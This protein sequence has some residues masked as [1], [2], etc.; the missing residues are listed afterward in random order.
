MQNNQVTILIVEDSPTQAEELRYILEKRGFH[1]LVAYNGKEALDILN[2]SI[3]SIV[4][5]DILMPEMDGYEL[6]KK[7]RKDMNLKELPVILVTSLSDPK[8]VIKGLECGANNFV[9]KP[10]DERYLISRINYQLANLELRKDV[11]AEMG[12]NVFFSGENYFITAER[13]QILDLLLSTY[14][15][16]YHQN[17]ELLE[18]QNELKELNEKL[19]AARLQAEQANKAKSDFLANM[20]HELRTPLNSIIGF[21]EMLEDELFGKLNEKQKEYINDIRSSGNHLLR[22]INDILDLSKVEAG[23]MELELS[24]FLLK[25]LLE[26]AMILFKEKAMRHSINLSLEVDPGAALELEADERKLKQIMFNLIGNAM[27]FTG[28]GGS[29]QVT[30]RRGGRDLGLGISEKEPIPSPQPPIPDADFV[31]IS[32]ADTGIGIKPEDMN[33]LFKEFSQVDAGYAKSYEGTGLGLA[34]AKRM[35][36]LHSGNIWVESEYGKGSRFTF[37]IPIRQL[38]E[39]SGK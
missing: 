2:K 20:S 5:S 3:P 10:Y 25:E 9:T 12:I 14:E 1:V 21:S 23:K 33:K 22:L 38:Q 24:G 13:L 34:L 31:E 18:S 19:E 15:T 28:D 26:A 27:K 39:N 11:K 36:E 32:V 16:A 37:V 6:C 30:V 8:D 35:V 29:V 4:V 17:K 7:I